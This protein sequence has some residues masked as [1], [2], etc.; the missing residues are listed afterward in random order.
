MGRGWRPV[1]LFRRALRSVSRRESSA[2]LR[3][4]LK[5]LYPPSLHLG[6]PEGVNRFVIN[7]L[8]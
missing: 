8:N 4:M 2:D 6:L 1:P 7:W 5:R 3:V